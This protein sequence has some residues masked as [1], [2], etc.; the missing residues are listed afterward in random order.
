MP[1]MEPANYVFYLWNRN[2]YERFRFL[3]FESSF[4]TCTMGGGK[5]NFAMFFFLEMGSIWVLIGQIFHTD[6]VDKNRKR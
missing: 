4:A 5:T 6:L 3:I 1:F 2:G